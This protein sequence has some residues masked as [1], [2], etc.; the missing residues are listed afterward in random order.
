MRVLVVSPAIAPFVEGP[1]RFLP[2]EFE[3]DLLYITASLSHPSEERD[4]VRVGGMTGFPAL[5]NLLPVKK[6]QAMLNSVLVS[7]RAE[8]YDLVHGHFTYPSGR[9]LHDIKRRL[10]TPTVL[11][12][13]GSD[14]YQWPFL[15]RGWN[16][17]VRRVLRGIDR[18]ITVSRRNADLLLGD[19]RVD[20][21][22]LRVIPNG[23][24]DDVF[25]PA[26]SKMLDGEGRT[27]LLAVGRYSEEKRHLPLIEAM[28]ELEDC[29]LFIVG[30]GG[31]ESA[32]RRRIVSLGLEGR[33][34]L[35]DWMDPKGLAEAFNSADLLVHPSEREGFPAIL[36]EA[37]SCGL[38]VVATA[39]GGV[40]EIVDPGNGV[41][42]DD[43]SEASLV[44][45][46]A[47]ASEKDWDR[48]AIAEEAR[49]RYSY[50]R[51][52]PML[53]DVYLEASAGRMKKH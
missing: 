43:L 39:V 29:A 18:M 7:R 51:L 32:Y 31:L 46:I 28:A 13:H 19:G 20:G 21:S 36:P 33:V 16:R 23:V 45:A 11:T 50:R 40:P 49:E 9:F 24:D 38:P 14:V 22:R 4:G 8:G 17:E 44:D 10:G 27:V 6:A 15:S 34:R 41:L 52:S 53:A 25:R 37:L 2:P 1:L 26:P 5:G 3:V 12:G 48:R 42:V 47:T 35:V 30:K